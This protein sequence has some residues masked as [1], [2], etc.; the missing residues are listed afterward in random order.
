VLLAFKRAR[1]PAQR[2]D[3]FRLAYLANHGGFYADADDRCLASVG[4]FVPPDPRFVAFHE[5]FGTLGNN[6]LAVA[7][8]TRSSSSPSNSAPMRSTAE[9]PIS[10]GRRQ[11]RAS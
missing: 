6:F 11:D 10:Y 7:P 1:E 5:D 2:A 8:A 9:T 4:S 3:I